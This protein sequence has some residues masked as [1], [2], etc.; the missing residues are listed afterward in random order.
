MNNFQPTNAGCRYNDC[1]KPTFSKRVD[2]KKVWKLTCP[3]HEG[4]LVESFTSD[5]NVNAIARQEPTLSELEAQ[6]LDIQNRIAEAKRIEEERIKRE[7]L[8]K[9]IILEVIGLQVVYDKNV[10]IK[11]SRMND[12]ILNVLRSIRNR[13]YN[14]FNETNLI[15]VSEWQVF[16]SEIEKLKVNLE[17]NIEWKFSPKSLE[18]EIVDYIT[19]VDVDVNDN[20]K[21]FVLTIARRRQQWVVE[22]IASKMPGSK[23]VNPTQDIKNYRINV[24]LSEG[25]RIGS[26]LEEYVKYRYIE[27]YNIAVHSNGIILEQ[28]DTRSKIDGA[29]QLEDVD[30][31]DINLNG[32]TLKPFQKVGVRFACL[33]LGLGEIK[34]DATM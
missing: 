5:S 16:Q 6:L 13:Q 29:A 31:I 22:N 4:K 11:F 34:K 23:I 10:V 26:V 14:G 3:E 30:I 7:E 24:P 32:Q 33:A 19:E 25:W 17:A 20:G 2:G 8:A 28:I 12:N 1:G 27:N 18:K 15:P 9:P 21:E